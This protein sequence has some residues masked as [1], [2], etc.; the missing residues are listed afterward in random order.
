MWGWGWQG[1]CLGQSC[2]LGSAEQQQWQCSV[3]CLSSQSV[4]DSSG[5]SGC[6]VTALLLP[7][8][9]HSIRVGAT[10]AILLS[11]LV[12][13]RDHD[14]VTIL[15]APDSSCRLVPPNLRQEDI[16]DSALYIGQL[17]LQ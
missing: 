1:G 8:Y 9:P 4:V 14:A 11:V 7:V 3:F 6:Y 12:S 16:G 15:L 13:A 17:V 10:G 2:V 5:S